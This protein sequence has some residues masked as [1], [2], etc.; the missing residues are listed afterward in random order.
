MFFKSFIIS[1]ISKYLYNTGRRPK[2][3]F[4]QE[5]GRNEIDCIIEK[6][7]ELIAIEIKASATSSKDFFK[8]LTSWSKLTKSAPTN[9]FVVYTGLENEQWP[10]GTVISWQKLPDMLEKQFGKLLF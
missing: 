8:V 3:Y 4:S 6:A 9:N 1:E 7:N 5:P 2:I 10:G